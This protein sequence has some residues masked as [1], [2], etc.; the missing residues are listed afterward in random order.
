MAGKP[1]EVE[2]ERNKEDEKGG[3]SLPPDAVTS[4]IIAIPLLILSTALGCVL[5]YRLSLT[6]INEFL[7][8]GAVVCGVFLLIIIALFL[9]IVKG[10]KK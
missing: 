2:L 3:F 5:S 8:D 6:S 10:M 7:V 1:V 4:P 9:V